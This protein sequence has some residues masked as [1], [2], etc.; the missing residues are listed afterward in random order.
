MVW[1]E[2]ENRQEQGRRAAEAAGL[3][4]QAPNRMAVS[5]PR[6]SRILRRARRKSRGKEEE[7]GSERSKQQIKRAVAEQSF[8]EDMSNRR[9]QLQ[10]PAPSPHSLLLWATRKAA[11]FAPVTLG[12]KGRKGL[13]RVM[14]RQKLL[15]KPPPLLR[16]EHRARRVRHAQGRTREG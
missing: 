2:M 3:V 6:W 13:V 15:P 11:G 9:S 5:S 12:H 7:E 16:R 8:P 14:R 10:G 1:Q 4:W